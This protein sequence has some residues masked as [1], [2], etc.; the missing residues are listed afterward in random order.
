VGLLRLK[1]RGDGGDGAKGATHAGCETRRRKSRIT[2]GEAILLYTDILGLAARRVFWY[3]KVLL[4]Y[5]H[6]FMKSSV[7]R[8]TYT[9]TYPS[10]SM[11]QQNATV[12]RVSA[13]ELS[14]GD[15]VL[16]HVNSRAAGHLGKR[17]FE[18][19][20]D[21]TSF[22]DIRLRPT[23]QLQDSCET[24]TWYSD[25]GYLHGY[26]DSLERQSDIGEVAYVEK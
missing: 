9:A 24:H 11:A 12:E 14:E 22:G 8:N 15:T 17:S 26:H 10:K 5:T 18:A 16:V 4:I 3:I 25:I 1:E 21:A 2:Y 6:N 13:D 20:I 23:E 19:E 7:H